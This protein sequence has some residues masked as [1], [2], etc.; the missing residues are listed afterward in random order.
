MQLPIS[1]TNNA[2]FSRFP[3]TSGNSRSF[4]YN[5]LESASVDSPDGITNEL[6][7]NKQYE[8]MAMV[9]GEPFGRQSH[10]FTEHME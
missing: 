4:V 3:S 10:I 9:R 5:D 1:K 8:V 2:E 7:P 6:Q